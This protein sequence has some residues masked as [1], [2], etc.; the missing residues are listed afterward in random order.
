MNRV[1]Q[2][3]SGDAAFLEKGGTQKLLF[4]SEFYCQVF[5]EPAE[6]DRRPELKSHN[7]VSLL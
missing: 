3:A 5:F 6:A 4:L 2:K 1:F 7:I